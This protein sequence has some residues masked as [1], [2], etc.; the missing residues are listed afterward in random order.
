LEP[1]YEITHLTKISFGVTSAIVTSLA[2]IVS[3]SGNNEPRMPIIGTLLI[4]AIADNISDSLGIH[5]FQES[6][7]KKTGTLNVST[8]S[9]FLARFLIILSFVVVV[10]FMPIQLALITSVVWGISI[11][12]FL[13]YL[14][15]VERE[16]KP[17]PSMIQHFVIAAIVIIVSLLLRSW[18]LASF[19][20]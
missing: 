4:F 15:A 1:G 6:D 17:L 13:T 9:N 18:I 7:L 5:I 11:L 16:T 2:F 19:N 14:I 12:M 20:G 10:Y 3:L 8:V